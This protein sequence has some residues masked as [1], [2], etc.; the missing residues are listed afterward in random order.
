ME[1]ILAFAERILSEMEQGS[2]HIF[3]ALGRI[4]EYFQEVLNSKLED[5]LIQNL[6]YSVLYGGFILL[7]CYYANLTK[8]I[9]EMMKEDFPEPLKPKFREIRSYVESM[10]KKLQGLEEKVAE[11]RTT[12]STLL[13]DFC[14][15]YLL[16]TY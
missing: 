7:K 9:Q 15:K 6:C 5:L 12:A 8:T 13:K 16:R 4:D 14:T 11:I 3:E 2:P 1:N 10:E